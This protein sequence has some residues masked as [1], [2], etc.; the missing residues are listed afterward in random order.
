MFQTPQRNL[1]RQRYVC[2][3]SETVTYTFRSSFQ[4]RFLKATHLIQPQNQLTTR[5][6]CLACLTSSLPLI[7]NSSSRHNQ[8]SA[9]GSDAK[10]RPAACRNCG[11]GGAIICKFSLLFCKN[12]LPIWKINLKNVESLPWDSKFALFGTWAV[13]FL[14]RWDVWW[15]RKMES[16]EQKTS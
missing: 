11:G 13:D 14:F 12:Q 4:R 3:F 1:S 5:R 16:V 8:A 9:I 6:I 2:V 7:S 15:Y 10:E